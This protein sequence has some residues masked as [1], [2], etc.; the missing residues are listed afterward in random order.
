MGVMASK[1]S[2]THDIGWDTAVP[3][4]CTPLN[5]DPTATLYKTLFSI[6]MVKIYGR[7][8]ELKKRRVQ[9]VVEWG[10]QS[11]GIKFNQGWATTQAHPTCQAAGRTRQHPTVCS[12]NH[13]TKLAILSTRF[14]G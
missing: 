12:P 11:R 3:T 2:G 9:S 7:I 13:V 6:L 8:G 10:V 1:Y 4:L 14:L 5:L